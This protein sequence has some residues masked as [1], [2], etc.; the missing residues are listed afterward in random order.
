MRIFPSPSSA[1]FLLTFLGL[2]FVTFIIGRVVPIDPVLAVVGDRAPPDVYEQAKI[3]MGLHLPIW[4]QFF[5]YVGKVLR[6]EILA[7]AF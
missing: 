5:I 3:E 1:R 2:V 4:Q 7:R 6:A